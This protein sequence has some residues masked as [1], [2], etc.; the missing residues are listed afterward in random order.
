MK[1]GV[2][3]TVAVR[4]GRERGWGTTGGISHLRVKE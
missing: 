1:E 2:E 4:R 3:G